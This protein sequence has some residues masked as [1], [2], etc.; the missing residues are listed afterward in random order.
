MTQLQFNLDL[1][2]LKESVINSNLDMVIKS[3][4]VLVINEV[5]ENKRDNYLRAASFERSPDRRDYRNGYYE[6][7]LILGIGN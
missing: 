7:E 5:M 1:D 3:A 2:L 4:I 6:R